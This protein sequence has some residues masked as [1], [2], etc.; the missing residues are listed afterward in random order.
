MAQNTAGLFNEHLTILGIYA[1]LKVSFIENL[2]VSAMSQT[3][4]SL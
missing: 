1:G 4:K 2:Q 3:F